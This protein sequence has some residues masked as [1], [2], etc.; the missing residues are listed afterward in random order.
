MERKKKNTGQ[1][2]SATDRAPPPTASDS[3]GGNSNKPAPWNKKRKSE[4]F[5]VIDAHVGIVSIV[6]S[7]TKE[8]ERGWMV[9]WEEA[10]GLFVVTDPFG[11]P[12]CSQ[13][14]KR[15]IDLYR[16]INFVFWVVK[17]VL[18]GILLIFVN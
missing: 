9:N 12:R 3:G 7:K 17:L 8:C 5:I 1:H 4:E 11:L 6:R 18:G 10:A 14:K 16:K 15:E 2:S 13:L